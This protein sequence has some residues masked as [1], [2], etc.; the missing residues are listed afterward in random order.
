VQGATASSASFSA[1]LSG[2]RALAVLTPDEI[3]ELFM[4]ALDN[5]GATIVKVVSHAFPGTGLTCVLILRESHAVLHTWPETGTINIDI[6]S[7]TPRLRSVHAIEELSS[8]YGAER[9]AIQEI[10]RADGHGPRGAR[11]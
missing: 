1:D 4:A 2:C 11:E 10:A 3:T 5:A 9:L 7:C 6:F 8:R